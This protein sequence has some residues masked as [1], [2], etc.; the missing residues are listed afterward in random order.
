M[1]EQPKKKKVVRVET[2]A[3][4][5]GAEGGKAKPAEPVWKPNPEAKAKAT[6]FRTIAW[7]LW[8]AAIVL[9]AVAIFWML[10]ADPVNMAL[11][12]GAL[13]VIGAFAL[14]GNLLWKQAN[15]LDPASK[16]NAAAFALQ[17]QLG[18]IMTVVAF[19]PL[20]VLIV[21]DKDMDAKQKG[22]AGG[23]GA[24]LMLIIALASGVSW[25]GGPSQE[26]YAA[27][28]NIIVQL[29]GEDMVYWTKSGKVF[30]VCAEVPDVNRESKDG[31]IYEGTV[32]E[33]HAA[34]KERITQKWP[35][36]AVNYCGY[37]QEQVDA[38]KAAIDSVPTVT[39]DTEP[40]SDT[41]LDTESEEAPQS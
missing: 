1:A 20:I 5:T 31:S 2:T 22:I 37:T 3:N 18:A 28:E 17:N 24:I 14:G 23:I 38:V 11:L 34:G 30:H 8:I 19:L 21:L 12:I 15:R 13:V 33:A 41:E 9:E 32:A 6:R 27:E 26:Q 29:T 7:S 35:S 4:E 16:R 25:D 10:R 39:S 40:E 36:E